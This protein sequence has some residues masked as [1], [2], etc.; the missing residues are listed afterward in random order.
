MAGSQTAAYA[1]VSEFHTPAL[2]P[3]AVAFATLF[4]NGV[5]IFMAIPA[6]FLLSM[7]WTWN[8]ASMDFKR[9]RLYMIC[10]SAVNLF[11]GIIFTILPESAKF[12]LTTNQKEKA[13]NVLKRVYA[14]NTGNPQEVGEIRRKSYSFPELRIEEIALGI[15]FVSL[16]Q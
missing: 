9:W 4:L 7:N 1:Y 6:I 16:I 8:I 11:N 12:L 15:P 2:A 14:F 3:R 10:I 13:L 5:S